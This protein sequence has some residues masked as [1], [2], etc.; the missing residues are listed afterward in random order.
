MMWFRFI[1]QG[2]LGLPVLVSKL[3]GIYIYIYKKRGLIERV[4]L[5]YCIP[6]EQR[7]KSDTIFFISFSPKGW[8]KFN[9][10]NCEV[11][12]LKLSFR[13][14]TQK[15]K[16]DRSYCGVLESTTWLQRTSADGICKK[17][18]MSL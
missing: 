14:M 18:L 6:R 11:N 2:V 4:P 12:G 1:P 17:S 3:T 15:R 5:F 10:Q 7:W 13:G 8:R 16:P 9:W